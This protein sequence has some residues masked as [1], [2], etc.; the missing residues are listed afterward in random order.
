MS[1]TCISGHKW[2]GGQSP[3][4][5]LILG[6]K[7]RNDRKEEKPARQVNQHRASPLAQ[8]L[9]PPL[10]SITCFFFPHS[11]SCL[12]DNLGSN[13][14]KAT[15]ERYKI[16]IIIIQQIFSLARLVLT[17]QVT[18]YSPVL[19]GEYPRLLFNKL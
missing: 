19:A 11:H 8:G 7:R 15:A 14:S 16:L 3:L 2:G 10:N 5:P 17:R 1:L 13:V 6:T 4:N 9:D 12:S 18:K